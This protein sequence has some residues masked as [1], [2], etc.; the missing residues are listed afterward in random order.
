M[1]VQSCFGCRHFI[2]TH[3]V[4]APYAC[5]AFQFRSRRLPSLDVKASSGQVCGRREQAVAAKRSVEQ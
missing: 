4:A 5:R 1:I 3:N 2:V